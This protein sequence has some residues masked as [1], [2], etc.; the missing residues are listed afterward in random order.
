MDL[1]WLVPRKSCLRQR[2]SERQKVLLSKHPLQLYFHIGIK[3]GSEISISIKTDTFKAQGIIETWDKEIS[4]NHFKQVKKRKAVSSEQPTLSTNLTT[5]FSFYQS[6]I[7]L[8]SEVSLKWIF[9][10]SPFLFVL[11]T[12]S[13]TISKR[14]IISLLFMKLIKQTPRNKKII[15]VG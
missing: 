8:T 14:S 2:H 5:V 7:R 11:T 6:T 3:S 15:V 12:K 1:W 13:L 4:E 10:L 9:Q